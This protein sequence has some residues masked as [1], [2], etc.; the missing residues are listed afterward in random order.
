MREEFEAFEDETDQGR[1]KWKPTRGIVINLELEKRLL[2]SLG[3]IADADG[4]N[5]VY[6]MIR[7]ALYSYVRYRLS[8][9]GVRR[10][11]RRNRYDTDTDES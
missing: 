3:D 11:V 2:N 7:N 8:K 10:R 6:Q 5:S 4:V 1:S 9:T